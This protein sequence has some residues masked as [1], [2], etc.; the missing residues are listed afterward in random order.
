MN[1]CHMTRCHFF[2]P[3]IVALQTAR[4]LF[5]LGRI[6]FSAH[7]NVSHWDLGNQKGQFFLQTKDN[8]DC[9]KSRLTATLSENPFWQKQSAFVVIIIKTFVSV[10]DFMPRLTRQCML[11][12]G[13]A[14]LKCQPQ[15][16]ETQGQTS[17]IHTGQSRLLCVVKPE[18]VG[19]REDSAELVYTHLKT[20]WHTSLGTAYRNW[21]LHRIQSVGHEHETYAKRTGFIKVAWASTLSVVEKVQFNNNYSN[22]V[23]IRRSWASDGIIIQLQILF[24]ELFEKQTPVCVTVL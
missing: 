7:L 11:Q 9:D 8:V 21:H 10:F 20:C 12:H 17:A 16:E 15:T 22:Y 1:S 5:L 18:N 3:W 19:Q 24:H 13:G 23:S 6:D 4:P 2:F 14:A